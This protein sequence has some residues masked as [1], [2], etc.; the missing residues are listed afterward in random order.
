MGPWRHTGYIPLWFILKQKDEQCWGE[1]RP[2]PIPSKH[3]GSPSH[4]NQS[5]SLHC[6][7]HQLSSFTD[8]YVCAEKKTSCAVRQSSARRRITEHKTTG[9]LTAH[10]RK[11]LRK[12]KRAQTAKTAYCSGE[13]PRSQH[14]FNPITWAKKDKIHSTKWPCLL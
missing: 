1:L 13:Q 7:Q 9:V 6:C 8:G 3:R 2:S 11:K 10:K 4:R 14:E 12:S 5:K